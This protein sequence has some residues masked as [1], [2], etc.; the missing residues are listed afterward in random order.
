MRVFLIKKSIPVSVLGNVDLSRFSSCFGARSQI[1]GVAEK[2]VTRHSVSNDSCNHFA[3]V[4]SDGYFLQV[5]TQWFDLHTYRGLDRARSRNKV[6]S[7][8][9]INLKMHV[10]MEFE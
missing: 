1:D 6:P 4:Y 2:T 7:I 8:P 5:F 3:T 10:R 9:R